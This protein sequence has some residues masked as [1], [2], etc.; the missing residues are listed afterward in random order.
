MLGAGDQADAEGHQRDQRADRRSRHQAVDW[1]P[2]KND[3]L[4]AA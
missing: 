3:A 2:A 1:A 4:I